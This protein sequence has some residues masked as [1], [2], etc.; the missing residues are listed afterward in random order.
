MNRRVEKHPDEEARRAQVL[1]TIDPYAI[2]GMTRAELLALQERLGYG[3]IWGEWVVP[4]EWMPPTKRWVCARTI[5]LECGTPQTDHA[6]TELLRFA[7]LCS[8]VR[9]ARSVLAPS[10]VLAYLNIAVRLVPALVTAP[11][12]SGAWWSRLSVEDMVLSVNARAESVA[13]CVQSLYRRGYLS[14]QPVPRVRD[15]GLTE[16]NRRGESVP[17]N[18]IDTSKQYQ[19]LPDEF[20]GQCGQRALWMIKILGPT[21]LDC[22]EAALNA[23]VPPP[24]ESGKLKTPGQRVEAGERIAVLAARNLVIRSWQWTSPKKEP[25]SAVPFELCFSRRVRTSIE[26]KRTNLPIREDFAWPPRQWGDLVMLVSLL[27]TC[28]AWLL[29]LAS[30]PRASTVLSY[31]EKC[32]IPVPGGYRLEGTLHK[33]PDE[34][35]G[36]KR[37]W[38]APPIVVQ[39]AQQQIRLAQFIKRLAKPS[40]PSSLGDHL[41]VLVMGN[42]RGDGKGSAVVGLNPPLNALVKQFGLRHLLDNDNPKLH[43]HRFRK[44]LARIIALTLTNAQMVLMDCFGHDDPEMT[45]R[46]YIMADKALVADVQQAQ[47]EIVIL[48]AKDAVEQADTL[49]GAAGV[50]VRDAKAQYLR[51]HNKSNLDPE[52]IQEL[53]EMLTLGG[54]DWVIVMPGVICTLPIGSTGP[55]AMRQGGRN[56]GNCQS[57]CGHQLLTD[58]NKSQTDDTVRWILEELQK[59]TDMDSVSVP[60]WEGQLQNW[61]YRWRE[62]YDRWAEHPL[63]KIHGDPKMT[64]EEIA[65]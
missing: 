37:L 44:T 41:W 13:G 3:G 52:D 12:P 38:P 39:A 58:Y 61:L 26:A 51:L 62:V 15:D 46:H 17:K 36:R 2:Q 19:P 56:P 28:H 40:A 8:L 49:G 27:Q 63:V 6:W 18:K 54:R 64:R 21:L 11:G 30:G 60:M 47:R 48:M 23:P 22:C 45:L 9:G 42:K 33:T 55:C 20:T 43:T 57:G 32:L 65:A 50:R 1:A 4:L 5:R 59:A 35:G 7:L 16:R 10:S 53:A 24:K 34:V 29:L 31:T 14:D 25:I